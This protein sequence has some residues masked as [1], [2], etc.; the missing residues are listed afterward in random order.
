MGN[1]GSWGIVIE[2]S[3]SLVSN[4]RT[5]AFRSQGQHPHDM[6]EKTVNRYCP[7][8]KSNWNDIGDLRNETAKYYRMHAV[9]SLEQVATKQ[10]CSPMKI[11]LVFS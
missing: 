1:R 11:L 9:S 5:E 10:S 2:A 7:V 6:K 8:V 4:A 3:L